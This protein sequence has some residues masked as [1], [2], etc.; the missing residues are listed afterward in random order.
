MGSNTRIY[1]KF[2]GYTLVDC[3]CTLCWFYKE[4]KQ[5]CSLLDSECCCA[6]EKI[7]L[8]IRERGLGQEDAEQS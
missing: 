3:R 6:E 4:K 5:G 1:D 2:E 7:E 8:L